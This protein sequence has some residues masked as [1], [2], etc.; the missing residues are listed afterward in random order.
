MSLG[1]LTAAYAAQTHPQVFGNVL[2]QSGAFWRKRTGMSKSDEGW[3][4]GATAMKN[5]QPIRYYLEVGL[6]ESPSMISNNRRLRDVLRAKGNEV[7]YAE[8]HT[9]HDHFNWRVTLG[10]GI[11]ALLS[12]LPVQGT[13]PDSGSGRR[14][15]D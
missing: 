11:V 2:S 6:F 13:K 15:K 12:R 9:G 7:F 3:L 5:K 14:Q 4:P 10:D 8:Y 1:G